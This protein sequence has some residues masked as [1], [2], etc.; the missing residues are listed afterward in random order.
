[1]PEFGKEIILSIQKI[2]NHSLPITQ[3]HFKNIKKGTG[4]PIYIIRE[5]KIERFRHYREPDRY[6]GVN[7][8]HLRIYRRQYNN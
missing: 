8:K 2:N 6:S 4:R 1:L 3:T 7:L 5:K